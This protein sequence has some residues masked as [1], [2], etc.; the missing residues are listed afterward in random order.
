M[1][2][3]RSEI[4]QRVAPLKLDAKQEA[5]LVTELAQHLDEHYADLVAQGMPQARAREMVLMIRACC[6]ICALFRDRSCRLKR[7]VNGRRIRS[8]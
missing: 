5:S 4:S 2:D 6:A 1:P 3:W 8:R 7:R